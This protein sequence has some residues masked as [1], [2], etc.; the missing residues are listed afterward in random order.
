MQTAGTGKSTLAKSISDS[1]VRPVFE[2]RKFTVYET[3]RGLVA[4]LAPGAENLPDLFWSE[5]RTCSAIITDLTVSC[6]C[7]ETPHVLCDQCHEFFRPGETLC[8]CRVQPLLSGSIVLHAP[9]IVRGPFEWKRGHGD[10]PW[11]INTPAT[12][13]LIEAQ[14][15][16]EQV[17]PAACAALANLTNDEN[18][19]LEVD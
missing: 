13:S 2:A 15:L 11:Y 14:P 17:L 10:C 9:Q 18:R 7:S 6:A 4:V 1:G 12:T 19:M 8:L 3:P 16:P 5:C